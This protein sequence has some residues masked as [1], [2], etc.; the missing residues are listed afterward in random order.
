MRTINHSAYA[1]GLFLASLLILSSAAF[2]ARAQNPGERQFAARD[3]VNQGNVLMR[4][5]Q[6]Q[7]AIDEYKKALELDPMN[8]VARDNIVTC[9]VNW[10]NFYCRQRKYDDALK[11][12]DAALELE[13]NNSMARHNIVLVKRTMSRQAAKAKAAAEGSAVAGSGEGGTERGAGGGTA[14]QAREAPSAVRILTPG[15]K[16]SQGEQLPAT[17]TYESGGGASQS[18]WAK[19]GSSN[20]GQRT[21]QAESRQTPQAGGQTQAAPAAGGSLEDLLSAVEI[22]IYGGKQS[23]MPVMKRLEKIETDTSGQVRSGTI[24]E[25]IDFLR[26]N[27]GL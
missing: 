15:L 10:G 9:H 7:A 20:S 19:P 16:R 24:K 17:E 5:N 18:E 22:K 26:K 1:P 14:R 25:R 23:E 6:F 27:Y 4:G 12:Y 8:T 21:P 2:P 3:H 11:E 13:P